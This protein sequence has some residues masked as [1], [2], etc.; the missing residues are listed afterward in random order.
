MFGEAMITIQSLDKALPRLARYR[1]VQEPIASLYL[2]TCW[3]DEQQRDRVRL[4][5]AAEARA[6]LQRHR[7]GPAAPAVERTLTRMMRFVADLCDQAHHADSD[8][9]ALFACEALDLFWPIYLRTPLRNALALDEV[10]HLSQLVRVSQTHAPALLAVA[11]VYG[12]RIVQLAWG[13]VAHQASIR[14]TLPRGLEQDGIS[15]WGG[16]QGFERSQKNQRHLER[17]I[18]QNWRAAAEYLTALADGEKVGPVVLAGL[19]EA[20]A[21]FERELPE[22][23]AARVIARIPRP[24]ADPEM[25]GGARDALVRSALAA[26]AAH[27]RGE[28]ERGVERAVGEAMRGGLAVLGPEDVILALNE[29]RVH[30]LLIE[31]GY[32]G[33]G[34]RCRSCDALGIS[35]GSRCAFCQGELTTVESL[36]D[37]LVRRAL[38]SGASAE[39]LPHNPRLHHYNGVAAFLRHRGAAGLGTSEEWRAQPL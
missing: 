25:N 12:A 10:P 24:S 4:F 3:A 9:V 26:V 19:G 7:D 11:D 31:D 37:E 28:Q 36:G 38:R 15:P 14:G 35:D 6:M 21:S 34:W 13:E 23:I 33:N 27:A 17:H 5:L 32:G 18:T 2:D 1:S 20:V 8:G 39:V 30:Q 29:G 16:P 22:R